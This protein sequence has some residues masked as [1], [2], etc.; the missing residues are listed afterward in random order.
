MVGGSV[1]PS[2][3]GGPPATFNQL[4]ESLPI[5]ANGSYIPLEGYLDCGVD[6]GSYA[7]L[8]Y[9]PGAAH[10]S[11]WVNF[12]EGPSGLEHDEV[13][14]TVNGTYKPFVGDFD[15]DECDDVFW[16]APGA[17][18]DFVWYGDP[19][20]GFES[21]PVTAT[22]DMVPM[23]GNW[24]DSDP[25][26][27]V[28]WYGKGGG[29]ETIWAGTSTRGTFA[30][31][32]APQV[33]GTDYR[34]ASFGNGIFFY[35]PGTGAD[36]FWEGVITGASAPVNSVQTVVNGTYEP[37][38]TGQGILLYGP[39]TQTDR[40]ILEYSPDGDLFVLDGSIIGTYRVAVAS[41]TSGPP[42]IVFHAPG[43]AQDYLWVP[44]MSAGST[45]FDDKATSTD[46]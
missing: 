24:D 31:G 41:P 3:A 38:F 35:R 5:T 46:W 8:W 30:V 6:F 17:A 45:V 23:V 16:Y 4:F 34:T 36:Y 42:L 2:S 7:V 25:G 29:V 43:T 1:T 33:A 14:L 32:S 18:A 11:M 20:E 28:F 44:S 12:D 26:D 22:F 9:A 15:G 39:G 37:Y 19:D 13:P 10:D 21:R 40:F 27:D